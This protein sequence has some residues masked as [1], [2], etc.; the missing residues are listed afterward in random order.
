M[1]KTLLS[2]LVLLCAVATWAGEYPLLGK[3][4]AIYF[5]SEVSGT[6]TSMYLTYSGTGTDVTVVKDPTELTDEYYWTYVDVDG[7]K[8]FENKKYPGYYL[9]GKADSYNNGF[10]VVASPTRGLVFGPLKSVTQSS[11]V[12]VHLGGYFL[13]GINT[14]SRYVEAAL[15]T[16]SASGG[17][18]T[19]ACFTKSTTAPTDG[20]NYNPY[21]SY[22]FFAPYEPTAVTIDN[23]TDGWYRI[24]N[25]VGNMTTTAQGK[26]FKALELNAMVLHSN[27]YYDIATAS[28]DDLLNTWFHVTRSGNTIS[29]MAANGQIVDYACT[30]TRTNNTPNTATIVAPEANDQTCIR[31]LNSQ[32]NN[33]W[34][35]FAK[36]YN[37]VDY[38]LLGAAGGSTACRFSFHSADVSSYDIYTVGYGEGLPGSPK[39]TYNKADYAGLKV[40]TA[41]G[42]VFVPKGGAAPVASDFTSEAVSGYNTEIE[43]SES[44]K[45]ITVVIAPSP[46]EMQAAIDAAE[47]DMA[48]TGVGYPMTTAPACVALAGAIADAKEC[49]SAPTGAAFSA[50]VSA[51]N[52]YLKCT[53]VVMP[54]DGKVYAFVNVSTAGVKNYMYQGADNLCAA[55][56]TDMD[57]LPETAKFICHKNGSKYVFVNS[58]GKYLV[59]GNGSDN[60]NYTGQYALYHSDDVC[61]FELVKLNAETAAAGGGTGRERGTV[62]AAFGCLYV[63]SLKRLNTKA[64]TPTVDNRKGTFVVNTATPNMDGADAPFWDGTYSSGFY[65]MEVAADL[66]NTVRFNTDAKGS[67]NYAT[68]YNYYPTAVPEGADA[69]LGKESVRDGFISLVELGSRVIP[70]K[71][72]V[73]L[74]SQSLSGEVG[75]HTG[76]QESAVATD[77]NE[78]RGDVSAVENTGNFYVLSGNSTDGVGFFKLKAGNAVPA[79]RAYYT[80]SS[81]ASVRQ[82]FFFDKGQTT[83]VEMEIAEPSV[84]VEAYDLSGRRVSATGKGLFIVNGKKIVK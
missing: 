62:E 79:F 60:T 72:A 44:A 75:L 2:L 58:E 27:N 66:H 14:S 71:T 13:G 65:L 45:T 48:K 59:W 19:W 33:Y 77:E 22:V 4:Y 12:G 69:Y 23:L 9:Q 56:F 55:A 78:L 3:A 49:A 37:S 67:G 63:E 17:A 25:I 46:A 53:D 34:D 15:S 7:K 10:E 57:A 18:G 39:V 40:L 68:F 51:H 81:G 8:F 41:N 32:G 38:V 1:K 73:V 80:P 20:F 35:A 36:T 6:N 16:A 29:V 74:K 28:D 21:T 50:L 31:L 70:A 42:V 5:R 52:Q 64:A 30:A 82:A 61:A 11:G 24:Q 54:E 84:S 76:L 26:F 47:A 43:V 83:G